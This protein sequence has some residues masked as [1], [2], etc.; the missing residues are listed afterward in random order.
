MTSFKITNDDLAVR[1]LQQGNKTPVISGPVMP[2]KASKP[3]QKSPENLQL[4]PNMNNHRDSEYQAT[5]RRQGN[6]RKADTPVLLD[7]RTQ[8]DRRTK[9]DKTSENEDTTA[10]KVD[11]IV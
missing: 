4:K 2:V 10:H 11:E 7:T 6:R 9:S 5:Q 8:D 3:V 1:G